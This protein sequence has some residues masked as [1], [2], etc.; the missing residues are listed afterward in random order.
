MTRPDGCGDLLELLRALDTLLSRPHPAD[1]HALAGAA[2]AART[3][4]GAVVDHAGDRGLTAAD[5]R[6]TAAELRRRAT[7]GTS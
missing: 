7:R 2:L 5:V 3:V 4:I 6:W 1:N